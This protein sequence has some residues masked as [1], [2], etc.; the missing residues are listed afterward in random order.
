M[1]QVHIAVG[2]TALVAALAPSAHGEVTQLVVEK[3]TPMPNGYELLQGHYTGA[4]D[5]A[6]KHDATIADLKLAPR[7]AAG[8]VEYYATFAIA[9]PADMSKS[10][11]VLVYDV[12]NRG[13][14]APR[15]LGDGHVNVVSGWQG[16]VEEGPKIHFLRAPVL[17]DVTGPAWVRFIDMPAGTT[18]MDIKGGPQGDNDGR[19]FDVATAKGAHLYTHTSD[20]KP[21]ERSEVPADQWAFA[22][23]TKTP[24]PGTPDL[25]KLCVK[26]GFNP[27]LAYTLAFTARDPKVLGVG[28]AAPRDLTAFL[29]YDT[30]AANPL[31][32]KTHWA[33]AR[34]ESQSGDY[35]RNYIHLGFNSSE[36]GKQV[37][38]GVMPLIAMRSI[39]MN[40]RFAA[41]GGL[42]DLYEIGLDGVNWWG[43]YDDKVRGQGRHSL[44]ERCA[45]V[46][47]CPKVAEVMGAAELRFHRG[48]TDFVGTG[49]EADIPLPANVRRYYN[50]SVTHGGGKGGFSL[51]QQPMRDGYCALPAN[52]NPTTFVNRAVFAALVDWV[53]KD[54]APP[55]SIY[56]TLAG[57]DL[58]SRETF[59]SQFP[60][61]PGVPR[62]PEALLNRY[63]FSHDPHFVPRDISGV[64][65]NVPPRFAGTIPLLVPRVD[66]D[67]N[68]TAGI[69]SPLLAAP[70][71][72]YTGWNPVATG[73]RKGRYCFSAGGFIPFAKT[74]AERVTKGDPRPSLE[75]RY[76]SHA[77]YVAKVKAQADALVAKGYMLADDAA[78][79][80]AQADAASIP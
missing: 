42:V 31:A 25:N 57:G 78:K 13:R 15:D 30:S 17:H 21:L 74:K 54:R 29:R 20:S 16:D 33:I 24:F 7:D 43:D 55:P 19:T 59:E 77:D 28:F 65:S 35:L 53:S 10:S 64:L 80:I 38:D 79:T 50:A 70:L 49:A 5:P 4:L 34:G 40:F 62:S 12:V 66:A 75:E 48:G 18:T 2:V 68:E 72:T 63:D 45:P 47:Q 8:K 61:I 11:G 71:G 56:P 3:T 67:G 26:G 44:L 46:N 52:P 36:D 32:G 41:P 39:A 37:F 76:P 51:D 23:C 60:A 69:R 73:Y 22:D 9:K 6:N 58:V 14:G 27:A 1:K